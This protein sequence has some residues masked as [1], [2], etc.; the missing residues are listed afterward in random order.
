[1]HIRLE[2]VWMKTSYTSDV[3]CHLCTVSNVSICTSLLP[4]YHMISSINCDHL[5]QKPTQLVIHDFLIP[6]IVD[7][8]IT[9]TRPL[10][11]STFNLKI[12]GPSSPLFCVY[13][14][15][16]KKEPKTFFFCFIYLITTSDLGR[17]CIAYAP[18]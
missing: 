2:K 14:I 6:P 3:T 10:N 7:C 1:M 4:S 16:G 9:E 11:F 15:R 8:K 12:I 17:V 5:H 18:Q 13:Y